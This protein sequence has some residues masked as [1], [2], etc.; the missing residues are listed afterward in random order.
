M[1]KVTVLYPAADGTTFDV[2]YYRSTHAE[3]VHR[4][5]KPERFDIDKGQEGQPF[6]ALGHLTFASP[7]AMQAAMGSPDAG[8]AMADIPNF[9]TGGQP[10]LQISETLD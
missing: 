1:L 9:Y 8:E 5:L 3:I 10:Q 4:V 7:D 6:H 2:D